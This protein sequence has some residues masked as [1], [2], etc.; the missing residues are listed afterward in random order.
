M[1]KTIFF[2]AGDGYPADRP[3]EIALRKVLETEDTRF[4]THAELH[5]Y[6]VPGSVPTVMARAGMLE[7][8]LQSVEDDQEIFVV[9]RSS[10]AQVATLVANRDPRITA[11]VCLGYP[12]RA[13]RRV[14]APERFMHLATSRTPTLIIQG[15]SDPFGGIELTE[16]YSLSESIRLHFVPGTHEQDMASPAGR[17]IAEQAL[18]FIEGGWNDPVEPLAPLDEAHYLDTHQDV[19]EAVGSGK[20]KSAQFHFERW[21]RKERRV[22]R[23]LVEETASD[24]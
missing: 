2:L 16:E 23:L 3:I 8:A 19:A 21:A 11:V 4:V 15:A 24:D 13:P 7:D 14:L 17:E 12:F 18:K 20:L 22:F 9:G 5:R 10:G 6:A 1:P